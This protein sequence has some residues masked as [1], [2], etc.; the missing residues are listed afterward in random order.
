V[1]SGSVELILLKQVAGYL[2]TPVF[3]VGPDGTLLYYNEPAEAI[4]G[5]RY[6][7]NG[8]MS[9]T[10]WGTMF[11][12]TDSSG[13]RMAPGQLPIAVAVQEDRP[14]QGTVWIKGMDGAS[15]QLAVTAFPLNSERGLKLGAMAVFWRLDSEGDEP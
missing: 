14:I 3:L 10:E 6:E 5:L 13:G 2:A 7:E 1:T 12:P 4:L 8:E 15:R 11:Q 9:L